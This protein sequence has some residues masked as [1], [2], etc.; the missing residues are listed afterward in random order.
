MLGYVLH[1]MTGWF[2]YYTENLDECY[3][4]KK[5]KII[6]E[7]QMDDISEHL[8]ENQEENTKEFYKPFFSIYKK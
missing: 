3:K 2:K 7:E 6:P 1:W 4:L 8:Q 5:V